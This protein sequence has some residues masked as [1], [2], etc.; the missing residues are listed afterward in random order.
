MWS[1]CSTLLLLFF[2]I[3]SIYVGLWGKIPSTKELQQISLP[4]ASILYDSNKKN[5]GSYYFENRQSVTYDE[6]PNYL[7]NALIATEDIRFQQHHGIDYKSLLRVGIKTIMLQNEASGGGST[8]SQQLAKNLFP[9]SAISKGGILVQKIREMII[10]KRIES[11]YSK[12]E[13]ITRYLNTVAFSD[14]VYGIEGAA[15]KFFNKQTKNLSKIEAALLIGTLK[16]THTYNPRKFPERSK[17]RRNLVLQL[18]VHQNY[19]SKDSL[20]I[21]KEEPIQLNYQGITKTEGTAQYFKEMVRKEL[22]SWVKQHA[23]DTGKQYNIY[24]DGLQIYTTLN[25]DMQ[26]IAEQV[27]SD[28]MKK[29]QNIF[30]REHGN[31]APWLKNKSLLHKK[32]KGSASYKKLQS[33]GL[34]EETIFDSLT[35]PKTK[36]IFEYGEDREVFI[37]TKDSI[38]HMMKFL[39]LGFVS[40]N[41]K[42]GAIESWI[43]GINFDWFKYDHVYQSKRQVGSLFKPVVYAAAIENGIK[44]CE[45]FAAKPVQYENME[46]WT[47][48]NSGNDNEKYLN[49][50]IPYALRNSVNTVAVKVMEKTG[51]KNVI[52]Q[53]QKMGIEGALPE[54]PSLA[55]GTAEVDLLTMVKAYTSFLNEGYFVQPYTIKEIRDKNGNVL[56]VNN[57]IKSKKPAFSKKTAALMLE[58]MKGTVENG[59]ASSLRKQYNLTQAIAGKTGTTQNNKDAWFMALTPNQVY[60]TWVGTNSYE[61]G[62]KTTANGQGAK[63]ALPVFANLF[64]KMIHHKNLKRYTVDSFPETP[65]TINKLLDCEGVKKDGF[66]K[67]LF[68]NPN[69]TKKRDFKKK[70]SR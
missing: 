40:L 49:Y 18:M 23:K 50:S 21:L 20:E 42:T 29:L 60:G 46:D 8:I 14:N 30:E 43:G 37:S 6:L 33:L 67:R 55:L 36:R 12:K 19:L 27:V 2:F 7:I 63:A 44:P 1:I 52:E 56:T 22:I 34:N 62:F 5:I 38:Q 35:V 66:F 15:Y 10:A 17:M 47:P 9:R 69:K 58:I 13:I 45:Y 48:T 4:E 68:T 41:R 57:P 31:S 26:T 3:F 39:N 54:V 16:A 11:L 61:I 25:S 51:I 64:K 32:L 59:T 70:Q 53:A 28:H 65:I 24:T